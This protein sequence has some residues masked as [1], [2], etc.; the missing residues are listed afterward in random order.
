MM[1][2]SVQQC[3]G[4]LSIAKHIGPCREVWVGRNE[5][6]GTFIELGDF[7]LQCHVLYSE[8]GNQSPAKPSLYHILP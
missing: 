2:E 8:P 6:A 5:N 1:G 3:S 7:I 4:E